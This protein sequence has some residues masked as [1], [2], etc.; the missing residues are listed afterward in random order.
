MKVQTAIDE[1]Y[2]EMW[3]VSEKEKGKIENAKLGFRGASYQVASNKESEILKIV[4][5]SLLG[6][7]EGAGEI[8]K[9]RFGTV[10]LIKVKS[11]PVAV[12][13]FEACTSAVELLRKKHVM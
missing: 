2:F 3:Q 11:S 12:K 8:G 7:V 4:D 9:G 6:E 1:K 13:Y 5:P 10:Y